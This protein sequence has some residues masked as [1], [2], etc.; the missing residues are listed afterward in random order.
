MGMGDDQDILESSYGP[1]SYSS[2]GNSNDNFE[3]KLIVIDAGLVTSLTKKDRR[4]FLDLFYAVISNQGKVAAKLMIE[5]SQ[6]PYKNTCIH[7]VEF[8]RK[9]E[10][11]II[12]AHTVGLSLSTIGVGTI[13]KQVLLACYTHR[14]KLDSAFATLLLSIIVLEGLGKQLDPDLNI[15][16]YSMPYIMKAHSNLMKELRM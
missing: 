15:L 6:D 16:L 7:P 10:N 12:D 5:R 8:E 1:D 9:I 14:V 2:F 3:Y 11:I 4:N 13:L